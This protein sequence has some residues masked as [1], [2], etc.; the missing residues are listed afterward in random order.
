MGKLREWVRKFLESD[1]PKSWDE[2]KS[3]CSENRIRKTIGCLDIIDVM[4]EGLTAEES[5][6]MFEIIKRLYRFKRKGGDLDLK[7]IEPHLNLLREAYLRG[8]RGYVLC[9]ECGSS[10]KAESML[11]PNCYEY[12]YR[13]E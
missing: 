2:V 3:C 8:Q 7:E 10:V 13:G 12:V 11:C 6:E 5:V 1:T 9:P 4:T